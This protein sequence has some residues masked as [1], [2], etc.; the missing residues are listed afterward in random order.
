MKTQSIVLASDSRDDHGPQVSRPWWNDAVIYQIYPRSF[1]DSNGDGIGDLAGVTA[2][3]DYLAQLAVD[4]IWLSPFYVSPQSDAG[5]DVA[6]YRDVDPL[7]GTLADFDELLSAAHRRGLKVIVDVVPNHTSSAHDWFV[8]ALAAGVG[9]PER[10]LYMFRDGTGNSGEL[11]PN[12]WQSLFGGAAWTRVD[13]GQWY[14]HLFDSSQPDLNWR[15]PLVLDEFDDI[16]RFWLDRGVDGFRVDVAHGLIKH[17]ELPDHDERAKA[18]GSGN[19]GP[20]WDQDDVHEIYRR[21]NGVLGEYRGERM[22]V[23]EAWVA[24]PERLGRYVRANEMQQAFNFEFMTVGWDALA[25][26][27][28]IDATRTITGAVDATTTW[29]L[30][31]HDVVRHVSRLGL[32]D[33]VTWPKGIGPGDVQPSYELG[34]ARA[35]AMSL[36]V[37]ALPGSAYVFEG[38]ELGLPEHTTLRDEDRADPAF[39]RSGG[40]DVGRDG[41]RIPMPWASDH[42]GFGFGPTGKTWLPQPASFGELAVDR[43]D[44]VAGSTLELYRAALLLRRGRALGSGDL[45]WN[46]SSPSVL[47]FSNSGLRVV[48]NFGR[49]PIPLPHGLR[50]ILASGAGAVNVGELQPNHAVWLA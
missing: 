1:A 4:A 30:S 16:L 31:N 8:A 7:F 43:Q 32:P 17:D 24:P 27:R 49:T 9:S 46:I 23:A 19:F 44:G 35:R 29:V 33:P 22:L 36:I 10:A 20:M 26:R 28:S 40:Q 47:H 6:D 12:N 21:W 25:L 42:P 2:H 11:P 37:F 14:L 50:V 41:C 3:L 18:P 34:L 39:F 13:D 48:V 5:Y 15:N 45:V 38:E